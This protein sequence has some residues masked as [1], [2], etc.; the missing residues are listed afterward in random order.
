[1]SSVAVRSGRI[2]LAVGFLEDKISV[3]NIAL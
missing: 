1:M 3:E 2:I